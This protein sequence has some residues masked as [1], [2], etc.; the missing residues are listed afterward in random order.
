MRRRLAGSTLRPDSAGANGVNLDRKETI[1]PR[2]PVLWYRVHA[3][4]PAFTRR[5]LV[6]SDRFE[7][8]S[9]P[10]PCRVTSGGDQRRGAYQ[11]SSKNRNE[12]KSA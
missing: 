5:G 12:N 2:S 8:G 6:V 3:S 10:Q 7:P 1:M 4:A 11:D 9:I